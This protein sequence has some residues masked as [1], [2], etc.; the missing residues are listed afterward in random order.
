MLT[1]GQKELLACLLTIQTD[2][3][4]STGYGICGNVEDVYYSRLGHGEDA[5][6]AES[7]VCHA[8]RDLFRGFG[9]SPDYPV[10]SAD[11]GV[12]GQA[13]YK[14]ASDMWDTHTQYGRN[15]HALLDRCIKH[16]IDLE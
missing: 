5:C 6:A 10:D 4:Y 1:P 14:A 8:L 12:P 11:E 13:A 9:L 16:L 15:R 3:P 7:E 2:G